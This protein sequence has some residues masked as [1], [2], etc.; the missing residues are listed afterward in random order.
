MIVNLLILLKRMLIDNIK[1][2]HKKL[3][4][5]KFYIINKVII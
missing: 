3:S 4:D 1:Q 5:N 2:I